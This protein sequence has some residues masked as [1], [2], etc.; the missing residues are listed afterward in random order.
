MTTSGSTTYT[1]NALQIIT[2]ALRKIRRIDAGSTA[3]GADY[4]TGLEA[5]NLMIKAWQLDG[6]L[7]WC[8]QQA[9]L[10]QELNGASYNLGPSGDHFCAESDAVKTQLAAA[11]AAS[12]TALSV[13]SIAGIAASDYIGIELSDGTLHWDTVN[14]AP[15]GTT[16]NI[17][18]GLAGAAAADA[19]VF[20]YTSK[21]SRPLEV[22]ECRLRDVDGYDA[23]VD[24]Q[25]SPIQYWQRD[26]DK[27]VTGDCSKIVVMPGVTDTVIYTY[28]TC[29]D[30]TK[31]LVMTV[32]RT[33]E[34][35]GT[36][37]DTADMPTDALEACIYNLAVRLSPE[38]SKAI[39]PDV[40]SMAA[41]TY[42]VLQNAYQSR[43]PVQF[44]P[45]KSMRWRR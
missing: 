44:R 11:A 2:A 40:A 12:A 5:L 37:T 18:S 20:A 14:G 34:D 41:Y 31:R 21:L 1:R 19:Y 28:P 17:T 33:I 26:T 24:V 23:P 16:V 45:A 32:K 3:T 39:P 42:R 36:S 7:L 4:T 30:V 29:D 35:F 13:D 27:S 22:L 15:S 38:Y 8:L 6:V 10:H 43:D 25:T 9:V